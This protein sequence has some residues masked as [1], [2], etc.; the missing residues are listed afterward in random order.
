[1]C[2]NKDT[3]YKSTRD[4]EYKS[5]YSSCLPKK[6]VTIEEKKELFSTTVICFSIIRNKQIKLLFLGIKEEFSKMN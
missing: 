2:F 6:T 4:F 5:C 1:M 3:F